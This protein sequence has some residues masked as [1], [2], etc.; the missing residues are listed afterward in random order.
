MPRGRVLFISNPWNEIHRPSQCY[1]TARRKKT[2]DLADSFAR[3][4]AGSEEHDK[5]HLSLHPNLFFSRSPL[6]LANTVIPRAHRLPNGAPDPDGETDRGRVTVLVLRSV[7]NKVTTTVVVR[8]ALLADS[9]TALEYTASLDGCSTALLSSCEAVLALLA[10]VLDALQNIS[11]SRKVRKETGKRG[12][13][14]PHAPNASSP[15]MY[16]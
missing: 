10:S 16:S 3:K 6:S 12:L 14:S 1:P 11:I 5:R 15:S 8:S 4:P 2:C 7:T 13:T 9:R